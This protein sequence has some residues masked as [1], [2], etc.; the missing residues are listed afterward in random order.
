MNIDFSQ[1]HFELFGIA[2][3]YQI[4]AIRLEQAYR[5]IQAQVHPDKFA[6]LSEAERRL[7]MQ[8]ATQAN[9][10]YQTLRQPLGR[11]RYLLHLNGVEIHEET[12]TAMSP[13]F[14]MQQMEWREAIGE[15]KSARDVPELEHLSG[16]LRA[17]MQVQ[18]HKLA[19]FLDRDRDFARAAEI[20]RELKFMEKLREEI[21]HA[22]E[23]LES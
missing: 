23:Q 11:A 12:N 9:E 17:E 16:Q 13:A 5:D 21:N 15:A 19:D 20:V 10:A 3:A 4:D 14:L 2:P 7:S 6:Y 22:L 18:Q 1:N 8:W